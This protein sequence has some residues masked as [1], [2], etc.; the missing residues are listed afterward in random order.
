LVSDTDLV[1]TTGPVTENDNAHSDQDMSNTEPDTNDDINADA[2]SRIF[3]V[4]DPDYDKCR[5]FFWL[6]EYQDHQEDI[7]ADYP[8][9]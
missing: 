7:G 5:P 2:R 8:V 1:D 6:N 9:R 3:K 4:Q